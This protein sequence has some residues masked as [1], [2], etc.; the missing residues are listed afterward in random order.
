VSPAL[1]LIAVPHSIQ[2]VPVVPDGAVYIALTSFE[3]SQLQ[4]Y[5]GI[6]RR[7]PSQ[8]D[9]NLA[10]GAVLSIHDQ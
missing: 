6:L 3:S 7:R 8:A 4:V 1:F 9:Q 2:G 10:S 5:F